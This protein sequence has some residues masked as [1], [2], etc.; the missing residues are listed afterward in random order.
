MSELS[1]ANL[2]IE[3][4]SFNEKQERVSKINQQFI[5]IVKYQNYL[6]WCSQTF[7]RNQIFTLFNRELDSDLKRRNGLPKCIIK[8]VEIVNNVSYFNKQIRKFIQASSSIYCQRMFI[9]Y[10]RYYRYLSNEKLFGKKIFLNVKHGHKLHFIS[11]IK[12]REVTGVK[13]NKN[14][15]SY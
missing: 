10:N 5:E 15:R 1:S 2:L 11:Y 3:I 9:Y 12:N 8:I 4:W 7:E 14:F 13:I 6:Q